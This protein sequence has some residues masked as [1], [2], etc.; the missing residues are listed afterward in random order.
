MQQK[1]YYLAEDT[2]WKQYGL[3][4]FSLSPHLCIPMICGLVSSHQ[5]IIDSCAYAPDNLISLSYSMPAFSAN[6]FG[7]FIMRRVK[8]DRDFVKIFLFL[9]HIAQPQ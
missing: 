1:M 8:I 2:V 7:L 6:L 4:D 5:L 9:D 3:R